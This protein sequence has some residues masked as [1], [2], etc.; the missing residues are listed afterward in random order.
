MAG[1]ASP[2]LRAEP[3]PLGHDAMKKSTSP[4]DPAFTLT[5]IGGVSRT[6]GMTRSVARTTLS[7]ALHHAERILSWVSL[8][9]TYAIDIDEGEDAVLILASAVVIDLVSH[10]DEK[11]D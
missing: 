6:Q 1:G 4:T 7:H 2:L 10:P 8:S 9:D 5:A 11:I 3:P